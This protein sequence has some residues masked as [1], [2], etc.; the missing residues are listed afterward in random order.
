M[1]LA[2]FQGPAPVC[3]E[4]FPDDAERSVK[5]SLH[6]RPKQTVELTDDEYAYIKANRPDVSKH[7][8]QV[9]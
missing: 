3:V 7:L 9:G 8:V 5:G 1:K 2:L 4:G 6:L